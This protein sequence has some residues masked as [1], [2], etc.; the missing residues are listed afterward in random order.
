MN[1]TKTYHLTMMGL[2][3]ALTC[4]LAPLTIPLPGGVPLSLT[5]MIICLTVYLL[6]GKRGTICCGL[7][8]LIGLVGLPVFS[9]FAGGL[10]KL[11]GPTGGYLIGFL[12]MAMI[13]G[14]FLHLG[15]GKLWMYA[16][17]MIVGIAVDYAVGSIWFMAVTRMRLM[18]TLI[19]CVFPFIIVDLGKAAAVIV[20]GPVLKKRVFG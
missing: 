2:M 13:C 11:A 5:N 20:V 8:L 7:Y 19:A 17:G 6:G 3:T 15:K 16:L 4:I 14:L 10:G 18:E 9:G 1:K 12:F